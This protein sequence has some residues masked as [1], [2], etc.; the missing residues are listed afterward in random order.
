MKHKF[1]ERVANKLRLELE[2]ATITPSGGSI[3]GAQ[4]LR[5]Q[6]VEHA[7]VVDHLPRS[8]KTP[9]LKAREPLPAMF[10]PEEVRF[11]GEYLWCL[12]AFPV[13]TDVVQHLN[14]ELSKLDDIHEGWQ[15]S[16]VIT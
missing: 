16:E 9:S 8:A 7:A 2:A 5:L 15:A 14:Q 12:N 13:M 10:L 6:A 11:Y 4:E 3:L 1:E